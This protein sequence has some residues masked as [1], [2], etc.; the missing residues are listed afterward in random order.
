MTFDLQVNSVRDNHYREWK[1]AS[2]KKRAAAIMPEVVGDV[3]LDTGTRRQM[4]PGTRVRRENQ[5]NDDAGTRFDVNVG[6]Q[7][8]AGILHSLLLLTNEV[9]E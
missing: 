1:G 7:R 4:V 3:P 2:R 8:A 9:L 5:L 6:Y